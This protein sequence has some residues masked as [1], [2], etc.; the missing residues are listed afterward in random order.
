LAAA[1]VLW[2]IG[3][4]A[5]LYYLQIIQYV[6]LMA[7]AQRQQC[8]VIEVT[9]KRGTIYD[10]QMQPLAISLSV[11][12]VYAMPTEIPDPELVAKSA[13]P[14]LGLDAIEL[15]GR[16]RA[17]R[18]FCWVK[19]KVSDE[20]AERL[21]ALNLKG[22]YFQQEAKRFY[23]HHELAAHVVGYV[24]VDDDGLAGQEYALNEQIRGQAGKAL[25]AADARRQT[26]RSQGWEGQP[27]KN[28][29]LTLDRTIQ[30][31]VEKELRAAVQ[32][33]QAAGGT[34]IVQNPGTGE[35][36][37][38]ANEPTFDPNRFQ[39]SSFEAHL[40][41]AVGWVYE[42]GSTFKLVTL[43]AAL[44]EQLTTPN[45]VINCQHGSIVLAGHVIH[46][47][48]PYDNLTVEQVLAQ[49]SGVGV[50]KLALRL[51]EE[52]F[53]RYITAFGF[54]ART[55]IEAPGEERGLVKPPRRW[56]GISIGEMAMGQEVGV[57]PLQ[58]VSAYSAIANGGVLF[59][60]RLVRDVFLGNAHDPLLPAAGHRVV[61]ERT[62]A[63]MRQF[64]TAVV[65]GGTG[66]EAQ[67]NG[68]TAAGKTGT[69]QK[70]DPSG[71]YSKT[72]YAA[73][74]AGFAPVSRPAVTI[75]VV[76]DSPVGAIYGAE[77]AAPVFRSIAEQTLAYLNIPHDNP[78]R[79]PSVVRSLPADVPGQKLAQ[80]AGLLPSGPD[81]AGAATSSVRPASF[82]S[83]E[84]IASLG[85][86]PAGN[87]GTMGLE[88]G[89]SVTVPDLTGLA[90][91]QV[92]LECQH[93]GLELNLT[94]SGLAVEQNP[95]G[96]SQIP[97]GSHIW[98]RFAR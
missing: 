33:W 75:L 85:T 7:R 1:A 27:G 13:A 21:R 82:S 8:R 42:P 74:F 56:S 19:R 23:P 98:V 18:T 66:Q 62:A 29:V 40:N 72:H 91:R 87:L 30:Y 53:Y 94:G 31:I 45:E 63:T 9:P 86:E 76:I 39:E 68:Y 95:A 78:S 4:F 14:I 25:V 73:S 90:V 36:L 80:R 5:R 16:L 59:Q 37:A 49:S 32:K 71:S 89:P 67:L 15:E 60:P 35:V 50:I 3:L 54:G 28:V 44:E 47:H 97:V 81:S 48:E 43:A 17:S 26:F 70:I 20:Q 57:T 46:D 22:V 24:G 6:D 58:I 84:L 64:L 38:M 41:R 65:E 2:V 61:S 77:V 92:A 93:L 83:L 96:G 12:S 55:G 88:D 69:A 34:V 10:R 11:D 79:W 51:G 52:R